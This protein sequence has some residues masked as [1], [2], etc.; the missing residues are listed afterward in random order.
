MDFQIAQQ[1]EFHSLCH[2]YNIQKMAVLDQP[3][4]EADQE[5]QLQKNNKKTLDLFWKLGHVKNEKQ[6][7]DVSSK[8][9]QSISRSG[10]DRGVLDF[11][12]QKLKTYP[13]RPLVFTC[14][15]WACF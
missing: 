14:Q 10:Q 7:I 15:M 5:P 3:P 11:A 1:K 13:S 4:I 12:L 2:P 8:I 9:L 6:V